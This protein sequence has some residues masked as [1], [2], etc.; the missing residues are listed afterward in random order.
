MNDFVS[1]VSCTNL[2]DREV[3]ATSLTKHK[4]SYKRACM[5]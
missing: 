5:G 2:V 1:G 3:A 4:T